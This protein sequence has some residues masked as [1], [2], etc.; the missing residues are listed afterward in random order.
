M[1]ASISF[2]PRDNCARSR[3]PIGASG[4]AGGLGGGAIFTAD[5]GRDEVAETAGG[6]AFSTGGAAF[7]I[8]F[9]A[10]FLTGGGLFLATPFLDASLGARLGAFADGRLEVGTVLE[11]IKKAVFRQ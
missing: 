11:Y 9:A 10:V 8:G 4:G 6:A 7:L 2:L 1:R 3:R 5:G